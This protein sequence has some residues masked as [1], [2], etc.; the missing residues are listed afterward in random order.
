L[1]WIPLELLLLLVE[2][3]G[4][5]VTREEIAT[6]LWRNGVHVDTESGIHTAMRKLR[7][8]L[9]DTAER[10]SYI[11][12]VPAK[13]YRFI[14]QIVEAA[15]IAVL[16]FES[17]D[18]ERGE[19]YFAEGLT[20]ELIT[21]LGGLVPMNV[22]VIGAVPPPPTSVHSTPYKQAVNLAP[23]SWWRVLCGAVASCSG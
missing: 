5:L 14:S 16:P 12:T 6:R 11:E 1:E 2:R 19:S 7:A 18:D 21:A 10:P 20:E 23:P 22:R 4:E 15:T 8:A 13:G 9:K 17:L 3:N